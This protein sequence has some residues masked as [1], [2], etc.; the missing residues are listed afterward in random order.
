MQYC[1]YCGNAVQAVSYAACPRCGNPSNSAPRPPAAAKRSN[2]AMVILLVIAGLLVGVAITGIL[3]AIAI[4]NLLTAM[5][6]AKQK[7]T[8]ADIRSLGTA[9]QSYASDNNN[10]YPNVPPEGLRDVLVPKYM[11]SVPQDDAW[12]NQLQYDY[13]KDENGDACTRYLIV[14]RAKDGSFEASSLSETLHGLEPRG[15]TNPDC[16]IVYS[17]GTFLE[18]PEGLQH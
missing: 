13:L 12:G 10:T 16:D 7:R 8:M 11:K 14:S 3:E 15:T 4:P 5:Q 9:L 18:Y 17:N 1:A 2:T 6:R